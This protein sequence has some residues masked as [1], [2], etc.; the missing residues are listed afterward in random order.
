MAVSEVED[1][2]DDGWFDKDCKDK[3]LH[4]PGVGDVDAGREMDWGRR[5]NKEECNEEMIAADN[6]FTYTLELQREVNCKEH[7]KHH[8]TQDGVES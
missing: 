1:I 3:V 5:S 2:E 6:P 4:H 7:D 8:N